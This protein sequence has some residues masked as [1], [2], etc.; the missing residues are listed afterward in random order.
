LGTIVQLEKLI[1]ALQRE[2]QR[3]PILII[4]AQDKNQQTVSENSNKNRI[5]IKD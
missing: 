3:Q 2:Q 1:E 5:H 4:S